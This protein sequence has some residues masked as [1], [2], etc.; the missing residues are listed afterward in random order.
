MK[1]PTDNKESN[2]QIISKFQLVIAAAKRSKQILQIAKKRGITPNQAALV[3][4]KSIK[5][6]SLAIE[7]FRADQVHCIMNEKQEKLPSEEQL[8][9]SER[10]AKSKDL[11]EAT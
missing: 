7:E 2:P 10:S 9:Q 8:S 6:T 1:K 3:E 4:S 11:K 5:P